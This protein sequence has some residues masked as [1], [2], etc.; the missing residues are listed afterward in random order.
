MEILSVLLAFFLGE[1][2]CSSVDSLGL[3]YSLPAIAEAIVEAPYHVSKASHSFYDQA[4]ID[5]WVSA[6]K[7][8]SIANTLIFLAL[9]HRDEIYHYLILKWIAVISHKNRASGWW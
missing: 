4:L 9:T 2:R 6:R 1:N 7:T 3:W 8:Y 5:R